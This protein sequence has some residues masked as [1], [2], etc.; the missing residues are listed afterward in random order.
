[1]RL[2]Y[3]YSP[4][5]A[6]ILHT[7]F[8]ISFCPLEICDFFVALTCRPDNNWYPCKCNFCRINDVA[9]S[10]QIS[11]ITSYI[12]SYCPA[13]NPYMGHKLIFSAATFVVFGVLC[14]YDGRFVAW[15]KLCETQLQHIIKPVL[16][17]SIQVSTHHKWIPQVAWLSSMQ[18]ERYEVHAQNLLLN[19]SGF[20]CKPLTQC[21]LL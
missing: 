2:W 7:A 14:R 21:Q 19:P 5:C 15:L 18:C 4:F 11:A 1:M 3:K 8:C 13:L 17:F 16:T 9:K 12:P 20:Y 10:W 6:D